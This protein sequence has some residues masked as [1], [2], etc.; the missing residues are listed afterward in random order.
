[1]RQ[2]I[3]QALRTEFRRNPDT[4][5]WGQDIA[6]GKKE[7]IFKVSDGMQAEFGPE[8]VFNAPIAENYIVGTAYGFS[9]FRDDIRVV[10]EGAEFADYIWP[11]F[12]QIVELSHLYYR[13]NGQCSANVVVRL[14]SGGNIGGGHVPH[15]KRR[16]RRG[17]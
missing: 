10:I 13:S 4:Y 3:N 12:D 5:L 15:G 1:M 8:R 7:G 14:A 6:S 9:R 11:G 17:R 16:G 2:G